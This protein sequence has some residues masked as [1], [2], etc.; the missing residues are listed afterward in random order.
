MAGIAVLALL[1][2]LTLPP[3]APLRNPETGALIGNSP[4]MDSLVFL[5][6]LAFLA[7]GVAYGIGAKTLATT[8]A[9]HRRDRRRRSPIWR[10][11]LFL[12]FVISQFVAYFNYSNI[13]TILAVQLANLL[14]EANLG[15]CRPCCWRSS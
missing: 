1:L 10:A 14:K 13:G 6:M 5:I 8:N 4:F 9:R 7:T 12:F 3:G 15:S 2:F 11:C